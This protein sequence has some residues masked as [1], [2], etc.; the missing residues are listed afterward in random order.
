MIEFAAAADSSA[1]DCRAL[2]DRYPAS[3]RCD[4]AR[5]RPGAC[6][7]SGAVVFQ[8]DVPAGPCCLRG[9]P[10]ENVNCQRLSGLHRLI[11][12]IRAQGVKEV[13]V[14]IAAGDGTT[15][16]AS[17]GRIWQ[18]EPW[19]PGAADF[20]MRPSRSRLIAAV[21]SLARWHRAAASFEPSEAER[22]WF[23]QSNSERSPG[24][25]ERF[26]EIGR[27]NN[28]ALDLVRANLNASSWK[29]LAELARHILDRFVRAAPRIAAR[30]QLGLASRVPLQPCLRDVWHDHILFMGDEVTGLID[31]HAARS[32]SVATDLARLLGSLVGDDREA[33]EAA[34][35]AYRQIRPLTLEELALVELFDQSGVLLSGMTWLD[36]QCLEGRTFENREKVLARLAEIVSRLDRVR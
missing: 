27:W 22:A 16:F 32:D 34:I 29:E 17:E 11:A 14:P 23:F 4:A 19:M 24:L 35:D 31:A 30:M 2:L 15:H 10:A 12:H 36:W 7:F 33:R 26:R 13:A 28:T 3:Y 5:S 21:T 20:A 1:F 6:G 25:A 9:M 18:L 8:V